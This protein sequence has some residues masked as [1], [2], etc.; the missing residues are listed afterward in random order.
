MCN[1]P[2]EENSN[3]VREIQQNFQKCLSVTDDYTLVAQFYRIPVVSYR[4]AVWSSSRP[5]KNIF[6][7][8]VAHPSFSVHQLMADVLFSSWL[9]VA[10]LALR[11]ASSKRYDTLGA[12]LLSDPV[13][14]EQYDSCRTPLSSYSAHRAIAGN[15]DKTN[16]IRTKGNWTLF[17]DKPGKPGW[18]FSG[19][20]GAVISFRVRLGPE[21]RVVLSYL[22][23][24]VGVGRARIRFAENP[25]QSLDIDAL[26]TQKVSFTVPLIITPSEQGTRQRK[27]GDSG[28]GLGAGLPPNS[29]ANLE[30]EALGP[31]VKGGFGKLKIVSVLSC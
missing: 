9:R 20:A 8:D 21:P 6:F 7:D 13:L 24:Y 17:E 14:F 28:I 18:T 15:R 3:N 10:Q 29:W 25:S 31:S 22:R 26:W 1:P 11:C 4:K 12:S 16:G 19:R 23:S 2:L 30:I 27:N 5:F